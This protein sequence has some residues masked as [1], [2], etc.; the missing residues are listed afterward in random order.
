MIHRSF[1]IKIFRTRVLYFV[2][3]GRYDILN[4]DEDQQ[5][6][7]KLGRE[8]L[9]ETGK[10]LNKIYAEHHNNEPPEMIIR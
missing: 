8:Q 6:L 7:T 2:R 9:I 10:H 5:W 4:K 1:L 3:H